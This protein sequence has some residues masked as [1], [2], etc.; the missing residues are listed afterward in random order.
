MKTPILALAAVAG[1]LGSVAVTPASAQTWPGL[2]FPS[3]V[4]T[5]KACALFDPSRACVSACT[6]QDKP[7]AT[8]MIQNTAANWVYSPTNICWKAELPVIQ[9]ISSTA[10]TCPS[11]L[12]FIGAKGTCVHP[13][14]GRLNVQA[15]WVQ[16][17]ACPTGY[18]ANPANK[19]FCIPNPQTTTVAK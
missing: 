18:I 6:G 4:N 10:P 8:V 17:F 1:L 15:T 14:D 19:K 13:T 2:A 7:R 16:N 5:S 9:S 3:F 11:G 12:T